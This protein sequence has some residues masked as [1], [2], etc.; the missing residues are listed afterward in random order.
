MKGKTKHITKDVAEAPAKVRKR[1][2][3]K[4]RTYEKNMLLLFL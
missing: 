4:K 1:K 3:P 2:I